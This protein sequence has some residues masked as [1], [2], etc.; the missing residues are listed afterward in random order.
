MILGGITSMVG[1]LI[2]GSVRSFITSPR[3]FFTLIL[4]IALCSAYENLIFD[5][6]DVLTARRAGTP[7]EE[8]RVLFR[9]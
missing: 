2:F 4:V 3:V 6:S 7:T 9:G 5:E 8:D 1:A